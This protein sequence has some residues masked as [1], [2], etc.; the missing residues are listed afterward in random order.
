MHTPKIRVVCFLTLP[1]VAACHSGGGTSP[2]GPVPPPTHPGTT[3]PFRILGLGGRPFGVRIAKGGDVLV[4]EQDLNRSVHLDSLGNSSVNIA[5]GADPGDVVT[6]RAATRAYV[7]N[8]NDGTLSVI[9]LAHNTV[10]KALQ[11][12]PHNAY[13]LALSSDDSRL[14]V[15]SVDGNLYTVN[16]SSQTLGPSTPLGG[17]LQGLAIDHAGHFLYV[18]ATSGT[19]WRINAATLAMD[20]SV[21]MS[22]AAQDLAISTDDAELYVACENGSVDVLDATALT[23]KTSIA[24]PSSDPF[25]LALSPDDAQLYVTSPSSGSLTIIDRAS[26]TIVQTLVVTGVPRRVAFNSHGNAAYVANE[27]NWID[28]IE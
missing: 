16:T 10:L 2:S 17:A 6:D 14:F 9:D 28:V 12:A 19:I 8:F 1:L 7:S 27:G 21:T 18:S 25:G 4:T 13:R 3:L 11:V 26:R 20:K 22:C 24:V 23:P 5:V 15:T